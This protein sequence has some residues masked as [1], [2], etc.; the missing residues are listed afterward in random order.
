[1]IAATS[2]LPNVWLRLRLAIGLRRIVTKR[3]ARD[4]G[5][6]VESWGLR[7]R[8]HPLD[9]GCEKGLLFTPQMYETVEL[10][11]LAAE[12]DKTTAARGPFVFVDVGANVGL[13][14]LFVASRTDR[15]SWRIDL[16]SVLAEC[17]YLIV[18]RTRQ[19]VILRRSKKL[20]LP[21]H[22]H[23]GASGVGH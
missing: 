10:A 7:M 2:R 18:A 21:R 4:S 22:H 19:D 8:L 14:S 11:E 20:A 13:F 6:D 15:A 23:I 1:M 17:G 5:L 16:L 12:I 9:N 3:M